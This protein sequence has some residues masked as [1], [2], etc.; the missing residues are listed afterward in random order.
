[1]SATGFELSASASGTPNSARTPARCFDEEPA[2]DAQ[3][4]R[5]GH[6]VPLKAPGETAPAYRHSKN[7]TTGKDTRAGSRRVA[8]TV[9]SPFSPFNVRCLSPHVPRRT[10]RMDSER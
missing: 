8:C 3:S 2:R 10:V 5:P 7:S 4:A 9:V 6:A 1:M